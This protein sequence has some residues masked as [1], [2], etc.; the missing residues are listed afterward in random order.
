MLNIG[1]ELRCELTGE[2]VKVKKK[3]GEGGQGVVYLVEASGVFRALKWYNLQQSTEEQKLGIRSLLMKGAPKGE[4]GKRFLWPLDIVTKDD[5]E[6][7]GYLMNVIDKNKFAELGEVWAQLKTVPTR[8]S[9]CQISYKLANSY[10]Q[11]HLE[12]YCY[13]DISSGNFMFNSDT[14]EILIC[15]NDN[16]GINNQSKCQVVGTM[17][18]M[19][20]EIIKGEKTPSILTDLHSLAVLLFQF[21]IWHHPLHGEMEYKIRS[22]DLPAKKLVY[23]EDP[24]F[25]FDPENNNNRLPEDN[26]YDTPRKFWK[27]CPEPLKKLF[28]RAFTE[29]LHNPDRRVTEGEWQNVFM[30]LE[31]GIMSCNHDRA[32]NFWYKDA[33]SINCWY[34]SKKLNDPVRL[35]LTTSSGVQ[36]L[37]ITKETK[38]LQRHINIYTEEEN[39]NNI[40]GKIVQNPNNPSVW[41]LKNLTKEVWKVT[42]PD[43]VVKEVSYDRSVPLNM[44]IK[45]EFPREVIGEFEQ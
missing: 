20:P 38:L 7:F 23:G 33:E 19:A 16:I 26:E 15:D 37:V 32:E 1:D 41:G 11:L 30:E 6:N 4:A 18:Y 39:R 24:I 34:C 45:V 40:I 27:L 2:Y 17:E 36:N 10:R 25:I 43:G 21:W 42:F 44:G 31:D 9:M 28:I 35:K 13:R 14:G 8:R 22:W 12:G 5:S 3:L 29:G